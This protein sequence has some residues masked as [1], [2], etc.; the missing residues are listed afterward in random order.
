[1]QHN[2]I[3]KLYYAGFDSILVMW[4]VGH[5]DYETAANV[6][7]HLRNLLVRKK[8]I[9]MEWVFELKN[10]AMKLYQAEENRIHVIM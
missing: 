7:T 4:M 6:Y 1:M 3:K 9:D 2:Y 10:E 5:A 8:P